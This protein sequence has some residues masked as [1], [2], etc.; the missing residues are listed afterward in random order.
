MIVLSLKRVQNIAKVK[1]PHYDVFK[2][3]LHK[4]QKWFICGKGL[5]NNNNTCVGTG[6]IS[7]IPSFSYNSTVLESLKVGFKSM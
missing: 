2:T 5:N 1:N 4:G 3:P 6:S 7:L